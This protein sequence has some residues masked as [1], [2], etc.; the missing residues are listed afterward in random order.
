M[1]SKLSITAQDTQI[2]KFP[3]VVKSAKVGKPVDP[4][5]VEPG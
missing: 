1:D 3:T 4:L 2:R 5:Y